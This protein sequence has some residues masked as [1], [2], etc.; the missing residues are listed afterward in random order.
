MWSL[1]QLNT[2]VVRGT[3]T[4]Q[5]CDF[6]ANLLNQHLSLSSSRSSTQGLSNNGL[7]N[8]HATT[9]QPNKAIWCAFPGAPGFAAAF[10][11]VWDASFDS[12]SSVCRR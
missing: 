4:D 3:D 11:F 7:K 9:A 2:R 5:R 6:S 1:F 12:A 10:V 8:L